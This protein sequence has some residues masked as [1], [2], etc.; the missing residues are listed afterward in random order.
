MTGEV[1]FTLEHI[2]SLISGFLLGGAV[3]LWITAKAEVYRLKEE[4]GQLIA[5]LKLMSTD[6]KK[7][8]P[9]SSDKPIF[10]PTSKFI[11]HGFR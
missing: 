1:L 7:R 8:N 11:H 3:I 6:G 4:R 2:W 5:R 10:T 9:S